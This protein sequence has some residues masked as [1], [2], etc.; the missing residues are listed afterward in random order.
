M[1]SRLPLSPISAPRTWS[2][3]RPGAYADSIVLMHLQS[4][5][6]R[7]PGIQDAGVVMGTVANL[8]LLETNGAEAGGQSGDAGV[9]PQAEA[10]P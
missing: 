5:L 6:A 9:R 1:P 7:L 3:V 4:S 8:E 10:T 2:E